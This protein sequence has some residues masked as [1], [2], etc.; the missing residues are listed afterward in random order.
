MS[1]FVVEN[2]E[3]LLLLVE[4]EVDVVRDVCYDRFLRFLGILNAC[5]L[6]CVLFF[7]VS[8]FF[9]C[10]FVVRPLIVISL[11]VAVYPSDH[12][13]CNLVKGRTVVVV[14]LVALIWCFLCSCACWKWLLSCDLE[15]WHQCWS[16]AL[17]I[18]KV[19]RSIFL[20]LLGWQCGLPGLARSVWSVCHCLVGSVVVLLVEFLVSF[21]TMFE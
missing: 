21:L 8:L 17:V 18:W 12:R 16:W 11:W 2:F 5:S 14:G 4:V 13:S 7:L 1:E 9:V 3:F 15:I 10:F 19:C 20:C 6:I